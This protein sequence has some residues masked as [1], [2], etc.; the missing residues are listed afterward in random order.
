[1][2][3]ISRTCR[4]LGRAERTL[5]VGNHRRRVGVL[6]D[7]IRNVVHQRIVPV[8][9]PFERRH[10]PGARTAKGAARRRRVFARKLVAEHRYHRAV[11]RKHDGAARSRATTASA[12]K[13]LQRGRRVLTVERVLGA[14]GLERELEALVR[15]SG[16]CEIRRSS[17]GG[18]CVCCRRGNVSIA[19]NTAQLSSPGH[20]AR[21]SARN[22]LGPRISAS[23]GK[24]CLI[25]P[26]HASVA[27]AKLFDVRL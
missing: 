6:G 22:C 25:W 21:G 15:V 1:M 26:P 4:C 20:R 11:T 10:A 14:P 13:R 8:I 3:R 12:M 2:V 16:S 24:R 27:R 5:S 23:E 18:Q 19:A 17:M 7:Q 9:A